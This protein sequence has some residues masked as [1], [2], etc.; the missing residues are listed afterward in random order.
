[1]SETG[2]ELF[3][4]LQRQPAVNTEQQLQTLRENVKHTTV[5][6]TGETGIDPL[7]HPASVMAIAMHGSPILWNND[8]LN[9]RERQYLLGLADRLVGYASSLIVRPRPFAKLVDQLRKRGHAI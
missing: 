5:L 9:E 1:M 3:T 2:T 8:R 4:I 7:T 6:F